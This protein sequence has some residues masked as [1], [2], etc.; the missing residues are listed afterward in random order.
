MLDSG[1]RE[2]F[3]LN[4]LSTRMTPV[5]GLKRNSLPP[6]SP[7]CGESNTPASARVGGSSRRVGRRYFGRA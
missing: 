2:R 1:Q 5:F 4:I 7:L 6:S 3:I